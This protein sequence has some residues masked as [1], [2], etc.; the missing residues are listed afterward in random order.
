MDYISG[1]V[2]F[3]FIAFYAALIFFY[4]WGSSRVGMAAERK[5]RNRRSFFWLSLVFSPLV[6]ALIVAT[7]PFPEQESKNIKAKRIQQSN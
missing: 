2:I 1:F 6:T 5:N 7:L 4:F 3:L